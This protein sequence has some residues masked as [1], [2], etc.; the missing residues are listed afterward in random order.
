MLAFAGR[1]WA[2]AR[3]TASLEHAKNVPLKLGLSLSKRFS[4]IFVPEPW[5]TLGASLRR[6]ESHGEESATEPSSFFKR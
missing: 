6:Q 3:S 1:D 5:G 2:P 4:F